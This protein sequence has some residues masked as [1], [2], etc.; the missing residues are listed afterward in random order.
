MLN[1]IQTS[2]DRFNHSFRLIRISDPDRPRARFFGPMAVPNKEQSISDREHLPG[3]GSSI[4]AL[5]GRMPETHKSYDFKA[6]A[7][8]FHSAGI[9][10]VYRRQG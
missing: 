1:A 9:A 5:L 8:R 6:L 10:Y 7:L 3:A 2:D 4:V